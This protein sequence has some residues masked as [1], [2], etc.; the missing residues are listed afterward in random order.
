MYLDE[1]DPGMA[2]ICVQNPTAGAFPGDRLR[3][4]VSLGDGARL[5]LTGQAATQ[6]F[7]G[8]GDSTGE[9]AHVFEFDLPEGSV[10]EHL[11]KS[12]IPHAGSRYRQSTEIRIADGAVYLGWESLAAGRIGHGERFAF[13]SFTATTT[14]RHDGHIGVRDVVK[15]VPAVR[16][17]RRLGL[18]AGHDQVASFLALAPGR[19]TSALVGT[20][21]DKLE[22]LPDVLGACSAL[23]AELGVTVRLLASRGPALH[24]ALREIWS[25]AR[26]DLLG[27][28]APMTR[29]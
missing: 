6:I 24:T 27:R 20:L 21:H 17:P 12:S 26:T 25:A 10:L 13:E 9:S 22:A 7:A 1:A 5:H 15:V 3:T 8:A 16:D 2:F 14:V 11:P 4:A 23:P 28:P 19:D 29:M 18:L